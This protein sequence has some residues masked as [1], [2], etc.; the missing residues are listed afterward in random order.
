MIGLIAARLHVDEED[1]GDDG[2][3]IEENHDWEVE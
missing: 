3:S 2:E 1:E